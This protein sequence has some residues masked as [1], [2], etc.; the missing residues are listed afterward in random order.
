MVFGKI[1]ENINTSANL[2]KKNLNC[3]EKV[4]ELILITTVPQK[5][6]YHCSTVTLLQL[7]HSETVAILPE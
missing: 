1:R 2:Q 5:H 6:C 7:F 3:H 4:R